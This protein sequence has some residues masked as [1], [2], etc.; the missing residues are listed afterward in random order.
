MA[1]VE[2]SPPASPMIWWG[3]VFAPFVYLGL[4]LFVVEAP[5][6]AVAPSLPAILVGIAAL[7]TAVAQVLWVQVKR[8]TLTTL[9]TSGG[10]PA[11]WAVIVWAL[12]E[13]PAV[14]GLVLAFL[15]APQGVSFTLIGLSLLA[16]L[17]NPYWTLES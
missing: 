5:A 17:M 12:D 8:G 4:I 9:Q 16:L 2:K 13:G 7:E 11:P 15:G 10:A 1:V 14:L 6:A 3:L